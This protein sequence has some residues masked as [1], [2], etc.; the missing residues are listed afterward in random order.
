VSANGGRFSAYLPAE[1]DLLTQRAKEESTSE[2]WLVRLGVRV[3]L[4]LPV[5]E[6]ERRRLLESL[7]R[8]ETA[9]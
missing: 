8:E 7:E 9:A 4:G 5:P 6:R 3:V 1:R 2:N